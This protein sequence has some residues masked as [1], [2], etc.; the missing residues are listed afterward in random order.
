MKMRN[1]PVGGEGWAL[2]A[3]RPLDGTRPVP[4]VAVD[5]SWADSDGSL[6]ARAAAEALRLGAG[7][8]LGWIESTANLGIELYDVVTVDQTD[9]RVASITETWDRGKLKQRLSLAAT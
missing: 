1:S 7:V 4:V 2:A 8:E 5:R 6:S 3:A 9:A